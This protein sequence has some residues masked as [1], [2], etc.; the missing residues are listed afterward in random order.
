MAPGKDNLS[1]S[2]SVLTQRQLDKFIREY[3]I[4]LDLNPDLPSKEETIYPFR[5]GKFPFY[6]RVCNFANYRVPFSRF[7]IRVL[8]FFR[9]HIC[10]VNPFG[11]SHINHFEISCRA[12]DRR[13]DLNFFR[14]FYEFIIA[15]DWYTFAHRKGVPSPSSSERSSLKNWKDNF[16]WLYDRCLPADMGWRFKDQTMSFD[17]GEGFVFDQE[18]ARALIEHKYHNVSCGCSEGGSF[19]SGGSTC[20]PSECIRTSCCGSH[21]FHPQ[22][23]H[24]Q[25][26][27]EAS[28]SIPTSLK[29]ASSS[30]GSQAGKKSILDD[31][32]SDPEVRS[33]DEALQ[34][35]PSSASLK[36]KGIAREVGHQPL[37]RK[38]K[39]ESVQ[40]R[41]F[42]PLLMPKMKKTKKDSSHSGGDMMDEL[43]E[44]LTGGKF[45]REEAARAR[46]EP[47]PTFSGGFL[48]TNEVEST[49]TEVPEITS[50][51][52]GKAHDEPKVVTF[53]GTILDSSLGPDR[54]IDDEEDQVSSL[55]SS[56]LGSELMSFF[57]Y[58]D[59][60]SDDIEIDSA[61]A[62]EK[63]IPD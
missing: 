35:R 39:T 3:R 19:G 1:D 61:T 52:K 10:Q 56:W 31:V 53:S 41:S 48:P 14:Y 15:G 62:E 32:D 16:F 60:F 8:Q 33:L 42:D 38:R 36:S 13:P 54:F 12:L 22:S 51:E 47:T 58:A 18:L 2:V 45:S 59:V 29:G 24:D 49:E 4:P 40:I 25:V 34:Y 46:T 11:L 9:V 30:S 37:V 57:R 63:F 26:A 6:T 43:D 5:Q 50:K 17:L 44:H 7:F 23:T 20:D 21:F 28:S 55:P 27:V